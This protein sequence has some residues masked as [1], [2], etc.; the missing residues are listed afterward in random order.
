MT[1]KVSTKIY[2]LI[3]VQFPRFIEETKE[4]KRQGD[5]KNGGH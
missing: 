1:S 2:P 5:V 3:L 4:L